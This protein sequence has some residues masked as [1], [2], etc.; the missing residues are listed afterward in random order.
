MAVMSRR[1]YLP[2]HKTLKEEVLKEAH[3]SIFIV[4][5]GSTKMKKEIA[6]YMARCRVYQQVKIEY[7]KPAGPLQPLLILEWK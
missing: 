1:I 2:K 7:Q 3:E 6:K 4:Y 5:P